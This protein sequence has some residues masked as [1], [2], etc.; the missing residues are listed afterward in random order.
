MADDDDDHALLLGDDDIAMGANAGQ[1][2]AS[3]GATARHTVGAAGQGFSARLW[4]PPSNPRMY[5]STRR[6][7]AQRVARAGDR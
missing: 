4:R 7:L 6:G 1:E 5:P 2:I 3:I